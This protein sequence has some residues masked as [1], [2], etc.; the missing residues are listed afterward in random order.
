MQGPLVQAYDTDTTTEPADP[1]NIFACSKDTYCCESSAGPGDFCCQTTNAS[2]LLR[3]GAAVPADHSVSIATDYLQAA[4]S[5]S[6]N[7][8][9]ATSSL[10]SQPTSDDHGK[11]SGV[12]LGLG[13]GLG[14]PLGAAVI[15]GTIYF[16]RRRR[17]N[18][19][20]NN[21]PRGPEVADAGRP[22]RRDRN[23]QHGRREPINID[24]PE[25]VQALARQLAAHLPEQP[26]QPRAPPRARTVSRG[27]ERDGV[28]HHEVGVDR[29]PLYEDVL[30]E[31]AAGR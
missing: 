30:N 2:E 3:L 24:I 12:E 17:N 8:P 7:G 14:L 1:A 5:T 18:N 29:L 15:G 25:I 19:N 28:V 11:S 9:S 27:R 31:A 6:R 20:N 16:L 4:T 26:A 21:V 10:S 13:L 23:Q 22:R